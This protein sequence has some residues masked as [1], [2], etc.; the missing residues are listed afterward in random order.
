MQYTETAKKKIANFL[1]AT[2]K[3]KGITANQIIIETRLHKS[4]IYAIL[5]MGKNKDNYTINSLLK[6]FEV[7]GVD[8]E[9]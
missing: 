4:V 8:I 1:K 9:I 3:A 2:M 7:I 5:Q 6:V